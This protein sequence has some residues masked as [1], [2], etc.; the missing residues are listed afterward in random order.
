[1]LSNSDP[2]NGNSKDNFF[3]DLYKDYKIV[4]VPANRMINCIGEKRGKINE[5]IITNY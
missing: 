1:M 4:R 2:Q 5:L 3:D